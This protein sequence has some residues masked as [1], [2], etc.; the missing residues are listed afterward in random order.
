MS[1]NTEQQQ[2]TTEPTP[3]YKFQAEPYHGIKNVLSFFLALFMFIS[4]LLFC[5]PVNTMQLISVL[6]S[7]FNPHL[8]HK[9]NTFAAGIAFWYFVSMIERFA[10]VNVEFSGTFKQVQLEP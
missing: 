5:I 8:A 3:L 6:V 10:G 1:Q 7:Y 9:I 4:M 2:D